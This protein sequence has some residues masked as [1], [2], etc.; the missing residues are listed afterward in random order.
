M[1]ERTTFQTV[2]VSPFLLSPGSIP[3]L[4]SILANAEETTLT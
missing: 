1:P 2:N 3:S 4:F